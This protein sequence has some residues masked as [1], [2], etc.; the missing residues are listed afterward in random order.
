MGLWISVFIMTSPEL[1]VCGMEV[2]SVIALGVAGV[3]A[4]VGTAVSLTGVTGWVNDAGNAVVSPGRMKPPCH[5][6]EYYITLQKLK[7][8]KTQN[9]RM[10]LQAS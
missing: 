9:L 2:A 8:I 3:E 6:R 1:I 4:N 7:H 5:K 10:K